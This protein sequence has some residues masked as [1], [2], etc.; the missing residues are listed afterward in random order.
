MNTSAGRR[1]AGPSAASGADSRGTLGKGWITALA[2]GVVLLLVVVVA[3]TVAVLRDDP[4]GRWAAGAATPSGSVSLAPDPS[5]TPSPTPAEFDLDALKLPT[6]ESVMPWMPRSGATRLD[7]L[8]GTVAVPKAER[9]AVW[10]EPDV[11][12][13]PSFALPSTQ[14]DYDARWLVLRTE[15]DWVQVLLP[16]G[17]GALPSSDPGSVN[18]TAG[19]VRGEAVRVEQESRSIVIDLSDRTVTVNTDDGQTVVPAGIGAPG[20]PTPQG[21]SQVMTVT[22]ASNT[23]LSV[24]LSAQSESLDTFAGVDYAATAMHV[25]VG[26]GQAISNG[27]IRLTPE[28]LD[29]VKNLPAGVP[30]MVRA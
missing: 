13:A 30:V 28:G 9:T 10:A 16:Y 29:A 18:G 11:S 22:M 26:Q 17:R 6:I 23:G 8:P 2:V 15:G 19:W 20:T 21:V 27:C 3:G 24:F 4:S 5:P 7:D 25:G 1:H 12:E 14:Y